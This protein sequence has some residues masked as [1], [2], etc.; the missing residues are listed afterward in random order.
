MEDKQNISTIEEV[1][2][3]MSK[4]EPQ[5]ESLLK[6]FY[7]LKKVADNKENVNE[8]LGKLENQFQVLSNTTNQY[9]SQKKPIINFLNSIDDLTEKEVIRIGNMTKSMN[10]DFFEL[11]KK[12]ISEHEN[13]N[14]G[15]WGKMNKR[16]QQLYLRIYS[17]FSKCLY[18]LI[19]KE[20]EN[21]N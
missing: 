17:Y 16:V 9:A 12:D 11:M 1:K 7:E 14:Y 6:Y 20:I 19:K 2:S 13:F 15:Y 21:E 18:E 4:I 3:F 5:L 8:A 10:L